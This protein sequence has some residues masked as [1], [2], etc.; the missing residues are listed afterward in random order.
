VAYYAAARAEAELQIAR[1]VA[2][3]TRRVADMAAERFDVGAGSRLEKEQ[4]AL[5]GVRAQ[6]DVVDR[7]A[8]LRVTRLELA[9]FVGLSLEELQQLGD[10]LAKSG[11]TP[12]LADLLDQ[13]SRTHPE[14]RTLTA[15]KRAAD[16]RA[17]AARAELRPMFVLDLIGEVLDPSTCN[18][19]SLD[20]GPR[21]VG[22]RVNLGFDLPMFNLNGGPI[23]R[24]R[25]EARAADIKLSATWRKVETTLRSA[26]EN[27]SAA[28]VRA[29]F[30]D[31]EYVPAAERVEQMARE[32]FT[33]GKTGLLPLIESERALL[34]AQLGRAEAQ[35]SVQ[36][37]RADLEEASGVA[38]STP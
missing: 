30:F 35:F 27:W 29:H 34:D 31:V 2:V 11:P 20:K 14:L 24:A 25:A 23:E 38:L 3:L 28:T 22:P 15:E 6:Q 17:L 12:P 16:A 21:C 33:A 5:L 4:A 26:Y 9:R 18:G 37:A 7:Q 1:D 19:T 8:V 10:P 13:A 32:G 36:Q